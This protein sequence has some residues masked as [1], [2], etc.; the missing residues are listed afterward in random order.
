MKQRTVSFDNYTSASTLKDSIDEE[1]RE[2]EK[3]ALISHACAVSWHN[4]MNGSCLYR[5]YSA[6]VVYEQDGGAE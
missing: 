1:V 6:I 2:G 3:I 5:Y 4:N